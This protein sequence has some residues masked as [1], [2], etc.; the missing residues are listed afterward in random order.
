MFVIAAAM[1]VLALVFYG[2]AG[3]RVL[4]GPGIQQTPMAKS[5]LVSSD[6]ESDDKGVIKKLIGQAVLI[7]QPD[8]LAPVDGKP[9]PVK[10]V[11]TVPDDPL[12]L[13][14][15]NEITRME[16]TSFAFLLEEKLGKKPPK[17][18]LKYPG[19]EQREIIFTREDEEQVMGLI[20][21]VVKSTV[22]KKNIRRN[23]TLSEK[24]LK[25]DFNAV[26]EQRVT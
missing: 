11:L 22:T 26:C 5:Q 15:F 13:K 8:G 23:H 3:Y 24:C 9:A 17:G 10:R 20:E 1:G 12:K 2:L 25:C 18:I 14:E 4:H 6:M 21:Q 16:I 19:R 7:G